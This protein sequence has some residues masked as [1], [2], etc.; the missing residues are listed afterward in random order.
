M[1]SVVGISGWYQWLVSVDGIWRLETR[2]MMVSVRSPIPRCLSSEGLTPLYLQIIKQ[3]R[4]ICISHIFQQE[5]ESFKITHMTAI[6]QTILI[7]CTSY[8]ASIQHLL[9]AVVGACPF[10]LSL[11]D[12][13]FKD[14]FK[15]WK[16]SLANIKRL[17]HRHGSDPRSFKDGYAYPDYLIKIFFSGGELP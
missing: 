14:F 15:K 6:S 13:T 11:R 4:C 7:S 9:A 1:V 5:I 12:G 8:V 3:T 17:Q 2:S 16:K 10:P